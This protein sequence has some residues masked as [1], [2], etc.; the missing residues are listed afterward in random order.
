MR[1]ELIK[2]AGDGQIEHTVKYIKKVSS[3]VVQKLHK[4][5]N[6]KRMQRAEFLTDMLISKFIRFM[7][8]L[9]MI[10]SVEKKDE[11]LRQDVNNLMSSITPNIPYI[12][13]LSSRIMVPRHI[14]DITSTQTNNPKPI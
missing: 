10:D 2:L 6:K 14:Y 5:Y 11:L 3:K 4:E 8:G 1:S 9:D 7:G 13:F 12:G